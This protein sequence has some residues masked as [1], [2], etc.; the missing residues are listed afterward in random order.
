MSDNNFSSY[1]GL[2]ANS[3]IFVPSSIQVEINNHMLMRTAERN[4]KIQR[5]PLRKLAKF[6]FFKLSSPNQYESR[7]SEEDDNSIDSYYLLPDFHEFRTLT[8]SVQIPP[9]FHRMIKEVFFCLP[10]IKIVAKH[11]GKIFGGLLREMIW[12]SFQPFSFNSKVEKFANYLTQNHANVWIP[13]CS[14]NLNSPAE[15]AIKTIRCTKT[16]TRYQIIISNKFSHLVDATI[17]SLVL[18]LSPS[19]GYKLGV[20]GTNNCLSA[21]LDDIKKRRLHIITSDIKG[22][23]DLSSILLRAGILFEKGWKPLNIEDQE[24]IRNLFQINSV[25]FEFVS[26]LELSTRKAC[27]PLTVDCE[28]L[29]TVSDTEDGVAVEVVL[30]VFTI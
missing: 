9:D 28:V 15:I 25:D 12:I 19:H 7:E 8:S 18:T 1:S 26:V 24:L 16:N 29:K 17:N 2:R 10:V 11:N 20:R 23:I 5:T 21:T 6:P 30:I 13:D 3:P 4:N 27:W 14:N 22:S